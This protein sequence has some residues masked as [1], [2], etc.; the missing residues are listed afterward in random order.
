MA[1]VPEGSGDQ[2]DVRLGP[3]PMA[4]AAI[5]LHEAEHTLAALER[6][7][8]ID[9]PPDVMAA[10]GELIASWKGSL[11]AAPHFA[12]TGTVDRRQ[13]L[14]VAAH[15]AAVARASR[16]DGYDLD[17]PPAEA[18]PFFDALVGCLAEIASEADLE[19]GA[20]ATLLSI[21]PDF[22]ATLPSGGSPPVRRRVLVVDDTE[23]IRFLIRLGLQH[24][25]ELEI[26]GEAVDGA[27]AIE[28]AADLRPDAVLLDLAMPRMTGTEALPRLREI[29]PTARIVVFSADL[30]EHQNA[31]DAGADAF[32]V[33]GSAPALVAQALLGG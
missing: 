6:A 28:Q 8:A 16:T 13:I 33:K 15:W 3:L 31:L 9:I 7:N 24:H 2:L 20:G 29:V 26:C 22:D 4:A 12:W 32:V 1:V 23:D 5:W 14:R 11:G 10:F 19:P 30:T 17:A 25:P 21:V 27:D 18:R